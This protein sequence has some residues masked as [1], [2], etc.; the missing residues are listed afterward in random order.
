MLLVF[1]SPANA[2]D[3]SVVLV[4]NRACSYKNSKVKCIA[5]QKTAEL[6][7]RN[8]QWY[9]IKDEITPEVV[10]LRIIKDDAN[11]LI[12]ENPVRFSGSSTVH[13]M[14]GTRAVYWSE[15]SYSEALQSEDA[16][17]RIGKYSRQAK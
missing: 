6:F 8:G 12:L 10:P 13:L 1:A 2:Q 14:K 4:F 11:I 9:G 7:T 5:S 3:A 16:H 15:I 17:L